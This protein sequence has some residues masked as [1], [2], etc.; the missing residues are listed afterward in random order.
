[1]IRPA[2]D[3]D[4]QAL[5][6]HPLPDIWVG[7]VSEDRLRVHGIGAAYLGKDGRWWVFFNREPGVRM[8]KTAHRAAKRLLWALRD[9]GIVVRALPDCRIP[10]AEL[11]LRRLGFRPTG[12][13]FGGIAVWIDEA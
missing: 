1:M 8:K 6:D 5:V 9:A 7:L 12:E 2:T 3:Q 13:A 4:W 10:G 11:W